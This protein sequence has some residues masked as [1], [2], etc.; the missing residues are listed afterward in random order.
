[1][2]LQLRVLGLLRTSSRRHKTTPSSC[3][4]AKTQKPST[5]EQ[6]G[7]IPEKHP[8]CYSKAAEPP[9][10]R[11]GLKQLYVLL[12][13]WGRLLYF[14]KLFN[15]TTVIKFTTWEKNPRAAKKSFSS[16]QMWYPI[17]GTLTMREKKSG[18]LG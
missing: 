11:N 1:L 16:L 17:T 18:T 3:I 15:K 8:H 13:Y 7:H 9:L 14:I 6:K 4:K 10:K 5:E 2:T 12:L